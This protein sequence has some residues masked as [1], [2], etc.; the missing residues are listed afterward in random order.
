MFRQTVL[1]SMRIR[2]IDRFC[3]HCTRRIY[4]FSNMSANLVSKLTARHSKEFIFVFRENEELNYANQFLASYDLCETSL[5]YLRTILLSFL[6]I[7]RYS[8]EHYLPVPL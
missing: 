6:W 2:I 1:S 7:R 8:R 4:Y 3:L 5:V